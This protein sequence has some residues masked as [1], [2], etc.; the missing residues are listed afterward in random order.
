MKTEKQIL[1]DL[2]EM[3]EH[4]KIH[5]RTKDYARAKHV[6]DTAVNVAVFIKLE[7]DKMVELFGDRAAEPPV[8]GLFREE[9]VQKAYRECIKAHQTNETKE[10]RPLTRR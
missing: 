1:N 4:F 10:Y 9:E 7:E 8:I 2:M 3:P 6:Y 5:M